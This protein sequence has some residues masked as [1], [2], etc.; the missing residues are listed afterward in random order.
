MK[1]ALEVKNS[2]KVV[3]PSVNN[4]IIYDGEQWY[5]TTKEALFGEYESKI[6]AKLQEIQNLINT[7]RS[8]NTS[9]KNTVSQQ[10]TDITTIV[11]SIY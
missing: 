6:D 9:F 3:R 1:I 5:V 11:E 8:D 7:L 2:S 4:V 10:I